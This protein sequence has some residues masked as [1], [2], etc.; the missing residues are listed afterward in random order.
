MRVIHKAIET[1]KFIQDQILADVEVERQRLERIA[2]EEAERMRKINMEKLEAE[3]IQ[4]LKMHDDR[5]K[6]L[7]DQLNRLDR[8]EEE[9]RRNR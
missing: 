4:I 3:R 5:E 2:Y 9:R 7:Y 8:D 1:N 6:Q